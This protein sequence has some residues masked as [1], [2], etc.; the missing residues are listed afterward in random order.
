LTKLGEVTQVRRLGLL[1][2]SYNLVRAFQNVKYS[3][4]WMAFYSAALL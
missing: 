1:R 4:H 2:D 3:G